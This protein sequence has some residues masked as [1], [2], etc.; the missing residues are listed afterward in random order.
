MGAHIKVVL[1]RMFCIYIDQAI[2]RYRSVSLITHLPL[3]VED[4]KICFAK[5]RRGINKTCQYIDHVEGE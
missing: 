4:N 5:L 1:E 3:S 2:T